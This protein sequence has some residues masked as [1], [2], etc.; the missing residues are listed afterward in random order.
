[1]SF[2]PR[3]AD[4]TGAKTEQ[5]ANVGTDSG[6][7]LFMS[8]SHTEWGK[9]TETP[10]PSLYTVY[11]P[12]AFDGRTCMTRNRPCQSKP[13]LHSNLTTVKPNS[14]I[15][16][17]QC[18][19][20]QYAESPVYGNQCTGTTR[21]RDATCVCVCVFCA[22][23]IQPLPSEKRAWKGLL[24]VTDSDIRIKTVR[25]TIKWGGFKRVSLT[26]IWRPCFLCSLFCEIQN[27]QPQEQ[28]EPV[29][30]KKPWQEELTRYYSSLRLP[31]LKLARERCE[32][33][34]TDF[35]SLTAQE[36]LI[37]GACMQ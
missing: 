15:S 5:D 23:W 10:R 1:M 16:I 27:T 26:L 21:W 29:Q 28:A 13:R 20:A 22:E 35:S 30:P 7:C 17:V 37:A 3:F 8:L 11:R 9:W 34:C 24:C 19:G 6:L 2:I 18:S 31:L 4:G 14:F 32:L 33:G 25:R 12:T 36:A